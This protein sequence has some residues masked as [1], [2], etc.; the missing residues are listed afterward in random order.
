MDTVILYSIL[1]ITVIGFVCAALLSVASKVM[2]V[3]TDEREE[4]ALEILPGTNCG[5]CGFPGCSGYVK[6]LLSEGGAKT[7]LCSPGGIS[8]LHRLSDMFGAPPGKMVKKF[9]VVHCRGGCGILHKKMNYKGIQ[10]CVAAK[11]L[12]GGEGP[13]AF[14]CLG[15]GDCIPACP[16]DAICLDHGLARI[17]PRLCNSCGL[18]VKVCP[19]KLISME[20]ETEATVVMCKSIE[21]GAISRKKCANACLGC[22][23]CVRE[24]KSEAIKLVD[25]L[26]VIDYEKCDCCAHCAEIC[27]TK[28]MQLLKK[29]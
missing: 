23:K 2:A 21:K 13:C 24:C 15:Y 3:E 29:E 12:F 8:V 18:C 28:C 20:F 27:V 4:K 7:D 14:G 16:Q 25:H 5:A 10:S 9:A 22:G 19:N 11:Q 17:D 6:A 1:T 26:A